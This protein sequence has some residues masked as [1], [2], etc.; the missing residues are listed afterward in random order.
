VKTRKT[1]EKIKVVPADIPAKILHLASSM[2]TST[3]LT[4]PTLRHQS[5]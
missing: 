2:Q 1:G 5:L 3:W 4:A